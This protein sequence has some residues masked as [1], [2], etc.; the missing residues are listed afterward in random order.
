MFNL[1]IVVNAEIQKLML[2][3]AKVANS[4]NPRTEFT[5]QEV[6]N[7]TAQNRKIQIK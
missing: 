3:P 7:E 5:R 4:A 6:E 2:P 1:E